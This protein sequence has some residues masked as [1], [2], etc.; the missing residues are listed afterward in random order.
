MISSSS[1]GLDGFG[2][3][4]YMSC[5]KIIKNDIVDS[6]QYIF[7]QGDMPDNFNLIHVSLTPKSDNTDTIKNPG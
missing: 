4:F 7:V 1:P 5:W 2:G 3:G 6:V